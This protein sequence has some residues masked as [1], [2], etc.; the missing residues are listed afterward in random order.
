ESASRGGPRPGNFPG[1]LAQGGEPARHGFVPDVAYA[2]RR[3]Q[4]AVLLAMEQASEL[5]EPGRTVGA[6][7]G[8]GRLAAGS[9]A[10]FRSKRRGPRPEPAEGSGRVAGSAGAA[11]A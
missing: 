10:G 5:A 9:F 2:D 7:R 11:A 6:G 1:G 3:Q 8:L 4:G